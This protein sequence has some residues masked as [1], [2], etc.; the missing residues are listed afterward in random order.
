[1]VKLKAFTLFDS[2][3]AVTITAII[4]STLSLSYGYLIESDKPIVNLKAETEIT[5]LLHDIN[6]SKSYFNKVIEFETYT[7]QQVVTPYRGNK[8][9]YLITFSVEVNSK[10]THTEQHILLNEED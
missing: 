6:S 4:I 2:L 5:K 9:L 3:I 8:S 10:I 7:I 1:M